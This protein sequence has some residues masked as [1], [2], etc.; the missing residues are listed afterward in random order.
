MMKMRKAAA[1]LAAFALTCAATACGKDM[2]APES[3]VGEVTEAAEESAEDSAESLA[4]ETEAAPEES[5]E[6]AEESSVS[7]PLPRDVGAVDANAVTFED[8]DLHTLH[9][10][11]EG[12]DECDVELSVV[13][14]DGDKKVKVHALR[15]DPSADY[16]VV[17]LVFNLPEM[18]GVENVGK[19][20]HISVD[21]TC[22]ANETWQNDD[23]T[24][25]L[26]VGNFMGAL[27]GNLASEQVKDAD[28][29]VKQNAWATHMEFKYEDWEHS[30]GS[31]RCETDIPA[32]K[33]EANGYASTEGTT[34]VIMRW[35]Q[36]NDVDFYIDNVTFYD[37]DGN[38]MPVLS[39]EA[40]DAPAE[41]DA[42]E[43]AETAE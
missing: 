14:L 21:F 39:G 41:T 12:G 13:D 17:K 30:E 2:N 43:S 36:K 22:I 18:L 8:G 1:L 29:N 7:D 28:G 34:L 40:A 3:S 38:S 16:G 20:G 23:G 24:E 9:Q 11:G 10:M 4:D 27:A 42:A 25:S 32:A 31:W 5:A 19:I 37:K 15:D 6:N 26:V 35:G 33:I